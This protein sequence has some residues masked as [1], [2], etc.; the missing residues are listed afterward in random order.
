MIVS[1]DQW[2]CPLVV[3]QLERPGVISAQERVT[4]TCSVCIFVAR[5]RLYSGYDD[6][7]DDRNAP[8]MPSFVSRIVSR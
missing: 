4:C 8:K 5:D 1:Q 7:E 2:L 3:A 6:G